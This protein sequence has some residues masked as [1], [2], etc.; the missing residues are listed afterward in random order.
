MKKLFYS[1]ISLII[2]ILFLIYALKRAGLENIG[3]A[4]SELT[5]LGFLLSLLIYL[6]IFYIGTIKWSLVLRSEGY[7]IPLLKIILAEFSGFT[8]SYITPFF[9][10]GG[11]GVRA[12]VLKKQTNIPFGKGLASIISDKILTLIACGIL[13]ILGA[14][15]LVFN[16]NSFKGYLVAALMFLM[17]FSGFIFFYSMIKGKKKFFVGLLKILGLTRIRYLKRNEE[18][19]HQIEEEVQTFFR[20][21]PKQLTLGII[22]GCI[23]IFLSLVLFKIILI[24]LGYNIS[25]YFIVLIRAL[26][27]LI[28]LVPIPGALGIYESS[29]GFAFESLGLHTSIGVVLGLILRALDVIALI[30]GLIFLY[31]FGIKLMI[32]LIFKGNN[33]NFNNG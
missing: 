12:Y 4:I 8:V 31:R 28:S 3:E 19:I 7:K 20:D 26:S 9:Y 25:F 21:R 18:K 13:F 17:S 10:I 29:F 1:L 11:E 32:N 30:I 5:T 22:L 2:G 6:L 15:L 16:A 24:F 33:H 23:K 27:L 14:F